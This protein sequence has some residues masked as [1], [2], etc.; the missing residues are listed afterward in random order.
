MTTF[1]TKLNPYSLSPDRPVRRL[2]HIHGKALK[3]YRFMIE[4]FLLDDMIF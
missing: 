3:S 2:A 1:A 4:Y